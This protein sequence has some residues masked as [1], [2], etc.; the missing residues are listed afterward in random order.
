MGMELGSPPAPTNG[1][2]LYVNLSR[3]L[4]ALSLA[5]RMHLLNAFQRADAFVTLPPRL[6]A[7]FEAVASHAAAPVQPGAPW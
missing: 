4:A 7:M 1:Q 2:L 3:G 6:R 5:E